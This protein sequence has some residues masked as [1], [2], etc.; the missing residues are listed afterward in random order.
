M[1]AHIHLDLFNPSCTS[2]YTHARAH[3]HT[4]THT[5]SLSLTHTLRH[6]LSLSNI[7][8]FTHNFTFKSICT[9]FF[10]SETTCTYSHTHYP[11]QH[12]QIISDF[13]A[14]TACNADFH[15]QKVQKQNSIIILI[16]NQQHLFSKITI[17]NN[18]NYIYLQ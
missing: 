14:H 10:F 1:R 8:K 3:T 11:C 4:H 18:A 15:I 17:P 5:H 13:F 7:Q 9:G 12:A 2:N 16:I 6:S